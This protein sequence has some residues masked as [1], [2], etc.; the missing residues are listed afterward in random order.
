MAL[1]ASSEGAPFVW[2]CTHGKYHYD[3]TTGVIEHFNDSNEVLVTSFL[4]Y[5]TP[6]IRYQIGDDMVFLDSRQTC[7]CGFNS[8]LIESIEGRTADFLYSTDGAKTNHV[9]TVFTTTSREIVKAQLIQNSLNHILVKV[10]VDGEFTDKHRK[11]ATDQIRRRLGTD[12]CVT[13]E[14][15]DDIPRERSGKYKLIVNNV[16]LE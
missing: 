14:V 1:H 16:M 15:V 12:M 3:I 8:P 10:V 5:G 6:L 13:F 9:G 4:N 7:A 2:E 11:N